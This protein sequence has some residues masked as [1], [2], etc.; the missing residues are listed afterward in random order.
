MST[1]STVTIYDPQGTPLAQEQVIL[2]MAFDILPKFVA[3]FKD[4]ETL[5][6]KS[7]DEIVF[8]GSRYRVVKEIEWDV[9]NQPKPDIRY[10]LI[11]TDK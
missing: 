2:Q 9:E 8:D 4:G 1:S 3:H 5:N 7:G 10:R 11:E 6:L